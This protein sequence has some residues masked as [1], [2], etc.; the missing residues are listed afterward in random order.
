MRCITYAVNIFISHFPQ[1]FL[2]DWRKVRC[3]GTYRDL[4][5]C[6]PGRHPGAISIVETLGRPARALTFCITTLPWEA[7]WILGTKHYNEINNSAPKWPYR[8]LSTCAG[9]LKA[10]NNL[11]KGI[12]SPRISKLCCQRARHT[13]PGLNYTQTG[14]SA[15]SWLILYS[16]YIFTAFIHLIVTLKFLNF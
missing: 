3:R 12:K 2:A 8:L 13:A 1:T 16:I 10:S 11:L 9:S 15:K 4:S 14:W 7:L 6:C 5:Q